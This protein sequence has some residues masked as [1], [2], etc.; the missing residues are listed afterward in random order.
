MR[1]FLNNYLKVWS[2]GSRCVISGQCVG[3]LGLARFI[4]CNI[5]IRC[6]ERELGMAGQQ[7]WTNI[8]RGSSYI[9]PSHTERH[10]WTDKVV[11]TSSIY[12]LV[13]TQEW[14]TKWTWAVLESLL[15]LKIIALG[16]PSSPLYPQIHGKVVLVFTFLND[17]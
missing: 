7:S 15:Q 16:F 13:Q 11:H 10:R 12:R 4:H 8:Q 14:T 6:Q 3:W 1:K 17:W 2:Q 9:N 5:V